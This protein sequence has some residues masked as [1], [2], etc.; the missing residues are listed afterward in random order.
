MSKEAFNGKEKRSRLKFNP[1]LAPIGLEQLGPDL[2][3]LWTR[4]M[5]FLFGRKW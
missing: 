2:K 3:L 4:C 5:I 1:G